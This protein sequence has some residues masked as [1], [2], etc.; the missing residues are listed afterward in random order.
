MADLWLTNPAGTDV[1]LML[2]WLRL[3]IHENY[4]TENS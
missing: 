1:A 4:S 3:I 2:G